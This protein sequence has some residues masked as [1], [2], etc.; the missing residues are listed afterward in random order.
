M[1]GTLPRLL[2]HGALRHTRPS[3]DLASLGHLPPLGGRLY[4]YYDSPCRII[5]KKIP[6]HGACGPCRSLEGKQL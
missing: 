3:S 4:I 5:A 1:R 6:R 2:L